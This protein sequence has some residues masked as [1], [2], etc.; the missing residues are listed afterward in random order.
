MFF[1]TNAVLAKDL[2]T[3]LFSTFEDAKK[4]WMTEK[5][6][7]TTSSE[8]LCELVAKGMSEKKASDIVIMDLK[9][10]QH[11]VADYFIVCSGS[12]DTQIDAISDSI[13]DIVREQT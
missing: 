4:H 3:Y 2:C 7:T 12:S 13:E 10:I 5:K 8:M 1:P 9:N 11:A 6:Q